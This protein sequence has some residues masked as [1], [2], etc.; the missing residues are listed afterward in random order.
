MI[1]I[2]LLRMFILHMCRFVVWVFT[3]RDCEHCKHVYDMGFAVIYC[4]KNCDECEKTIHR[5]HFERG[6]WF[7]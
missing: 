6:R 2:N 7:V 5:K 4:G 3:A 1:L